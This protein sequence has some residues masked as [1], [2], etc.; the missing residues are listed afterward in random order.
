MTVW[1]V[2]APTSTLSM[3]VRYPSLKAKQLMRI[4]KR[5]P[6]SYRIDSTNGS[7]R[8][9]KSPDYPDLD[10][11]WHDKDTIPSGLVRRVLTKR[12][13]L[14]DEEARNLLP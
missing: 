8:H 2:A 13:G 12:I 10:F 11:C 9:L 1:R 4:L 5:K 14:T 7:H 6:L 3:N